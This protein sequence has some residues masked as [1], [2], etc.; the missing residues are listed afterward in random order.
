M[1]VI[2]MMGMRMPETCWAVSKLQ[3][4][5]LRGCCILLVDSVESMMMQH[6]L[7]NPKSKLY[8]VISGWKWQ[9][10]G[11]TLQCSSLITFYKLCAERSRLCVWQGYQSC[12][13]LTIW[14]YVEKDRSRILKPRGCFDCE[15]LCKI[16]LNPCCTNVRRYSATCF[17][18]YW[19]VICIYYDKNIW[20]AFLFVSWDITNYCNNRCQLCT[21][22]K[23]FDK[24][25][26]Q[27]QQQG[28]LRFYLNA[29]PVLKCIFMS[30][31][32][33]AFPYSK[34]VV[35]E[36]RFASRTESLFIS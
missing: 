5:N 3:V 6:G 36:L 12:S 20:H 34:C 18:F 14:F 1:P 35:H 21:K 15:E 2:I 24:P 8:C 19:L 32:L 11:I 30:C 16:L 27:I 7:A 29:F 33:S 22:I 10:Y 23:K 31:V 26:C 25:Y 9:I 17:I 4:I 28:Y 13:L